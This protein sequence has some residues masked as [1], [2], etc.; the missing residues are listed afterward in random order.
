MCLVLDVVSRTGAHRSGWSDVDGRIYCSLVGK[1]A[2]LH[3][4]L[5]LTYLVGRL[6][7]VEGKKPQMH[8][9]L[10]R[11]SLALVAAIMEEAWI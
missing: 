10:A 1:G 7:V 9:C 5:Q 6:V 3:I 2:K 11:M 8:N 4:G